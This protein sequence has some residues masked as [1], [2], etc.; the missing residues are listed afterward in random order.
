MLISQMSL[1]RTFGTSQVFIE[2]TLME[3]GGL[4]ESADPSTLIKEAI[5]VISC[6]YELKTSWGK[7][8]DFFYSCSHVSFHAFFLGCQFV[9]ILW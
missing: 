6:G 8:V 2:S 7:E 4:P 3:K 5:H 1:E 9:R